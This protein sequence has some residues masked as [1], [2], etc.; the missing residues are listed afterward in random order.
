MHLFIYLKQNLENTGGDDGV[1]C[2]LDYIEKRG[3]KNVRKF[4]ECVSQEHILER[5]TQLS[6]ITAALMNCKKSYVL[7]SISLSV[8]PSE[9]G[10]VVIL[11]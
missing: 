4:W 2:A 3:K 7:L 11:H 9:S 8:S 1:Y 5:Y 6:E 10:F